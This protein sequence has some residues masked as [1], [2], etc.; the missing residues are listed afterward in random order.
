MQRQEFIVELGGII[1][2]IH[3]YTRNPFMVGYTREL[4]KAIRQNDTDT[5]KIVLDKVINWYNDEIDK[6]ENDEY[7][8]NKNMHK[9]AYDILLEYRQSLKS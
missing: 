7:I 5:T 4:K 9:K 6:I 8:F 3:T 2:T 1:G